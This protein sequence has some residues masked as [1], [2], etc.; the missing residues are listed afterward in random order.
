MPRPSLGQA[1]SGPWLTGDSGDLMA[2]CTGDYKH[3]LKGLYGILKLNI[4]I[5][6]I[7]CDFKV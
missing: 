7:I 4:T 5:F 6:E 3:M 2:R 1:D